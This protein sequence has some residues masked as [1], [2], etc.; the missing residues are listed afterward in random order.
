MEFTKTITIAKISK[1]ADL[2]PP[3][4]PPPLLLPPPPPPP[5]LFIIMIIIIY[6]LY[7]IYCQLYI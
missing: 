1:L 4:L 3:L 7:A 2:P 6:H 5:L